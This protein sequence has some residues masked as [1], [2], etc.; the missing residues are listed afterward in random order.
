MHKMILFNSN[1]NS[2]HTQFHVTSKNTHRRR[3][4]ATHI[5]SKVSIARILPSVFLLWWWWWWCLVL[6]LVLVLVLSPCT[7]DAWDTLPWL[8]ISCG[9]RVIDKA[10][11]LSIR[12]WGRLVKSR[13]DTLE[14]LHLEHFFD[15]RYWW[16]SVVRGASSANVMS[17][18]RSS[19][20]WPG[21]RTFAHLAL[22]T[23]H[24]GVW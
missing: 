14:L 4:Q 23:R 5:L 9:S 7:L 8:Q 13:L 3:K 11:P 1:S 10:M 2:N 20:S 19:V 24:I 15:L 18:A 16:L 21:F 17:A 6:V 12:T 22:E